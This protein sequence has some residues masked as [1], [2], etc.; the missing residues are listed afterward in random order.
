[1]AILPALAVSIAFGSISIPVAT[2]FSMLLGNGAGVEETLKVIILQLRLPKAIAAFFVGG[3]LS[4]VGVAMQALVRNPLAEPYVLGVSGGASAGASLFY[5]GLVPTLIATQLDLAFASFLGAL[6]SISMVYLVARSSGSLSVSRL[7][8]AGVAMA[9]FM[10]AISSFVYF[11]TPDLNRM[12]SVLFWLM[13]SFYHITWADLPAAIAVTLAGGGILLGLSRSLDAMLIGE[14]PAQSLGVPVESVKKILIVLSALVTGTLVSVSGAIG[15]VGLIIPH[16]V[17]SLMGVNHR[18]VLPGSFL[19]G[20]IFLVLADT[21]ARSILPG[22]Q[23]PVGI[24]TAIAGVPFFLFL[25]RRTDY[26][27]K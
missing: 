12:R 24:V 5:L 10:A 9:S 3:G 11:A 27:F 7:L 13:G 20:G 8:L 2:T 6:L 15:F 14:E 17:R 18:Y 21:L 16:S 19:A 1:M 22:Q 25:L 23:L 26:Q 4:L